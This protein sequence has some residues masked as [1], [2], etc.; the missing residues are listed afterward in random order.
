MNFVANL[1]NIGMCRSK[2][3]RHKQGYVISDL[4]TVNEVCLINNQAKQF[5]LYKGRKCS[6]AD[7]EN[8]IIILEQVKSKTTLEIAQ[9]TD[10]R[11]HTIKDFVNDPMKV[12]QRVDK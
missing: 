12:G 8:V 7:A 9:M 1:G 3:A 4:I 2:I 10:R 6:L 5:V 11:H